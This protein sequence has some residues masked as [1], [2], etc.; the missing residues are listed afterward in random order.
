MHS[1]ENSINVD[2]QMHMNQVAT[3]ALMLFDAV[4]KVIPDYTRL[5]RKL[6]YEA[7]LLHD[8]G[9]KISRASHH[10]HS[11]NLI[12]DMELPDFTEC[13]KKI[14]AHVAR[15]H[16]SS[17]PDETKHKRY[18]TLSV[19]QKNVVKRLAALLRI[20]DGLD[21]P[22]KNLVTGME[23]FDEIDSYRLVLRTVGYPI[24]LKMADRKKDFFEHLY[25][26]SLKIV[27]KRL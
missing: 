7:A 3:Y 22:S 24:K 9:Y 14:I 21:K 12:L 18:S 15:Y 10:K 27:Y 2:K 25:S 17:F 11:L 8:I 23:F 6:L 20:A 26:K 5:E 4:E 19:E 1:G 13:E 16:R